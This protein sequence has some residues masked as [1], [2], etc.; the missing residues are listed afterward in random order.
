MRVLWHALHGKRVLFVYARSIYIK[1]HKGYVR[2]FDIPHDSPNC[3]TLATKRFATVAAM[4][5]TY[6]RKDVLL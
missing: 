6:N 3:P 1:P 5:V 2:G 4:L